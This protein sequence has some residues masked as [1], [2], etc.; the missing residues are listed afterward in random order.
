MAEDG[1]SSH[2]RIP[3]G[4]FYENENEF[5]R[6]VCRD[7]PDIR[8]N[9]RAVQDSAAKLAR[10]VEEQ[11][12]ESVQLR[13]EALDNMLT[14]DLKKEPSVK[15]GTGKEGVDYYIYTPKEKQKKGTLKRYT[16]RDFEAAVYEYRD[17][18]ASAV[19]TV[20][21]ILRKL[22]EKCDDDITSVRQSTHWALFF[23]AARLHTSA[24]QQRKWCIPEMI[25]FPNQFEDGDVGRVIPA[26]K[27]SLYGNREKADAQRIA[28]GMM[29]TGMIPYWMKR[30]SA[31]ANDIELAGMVLLTAPNMSGKSTLM[32]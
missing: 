21:T 11:I 8:A 17:A 30:S 1:I 27:L 4:F 15:D 20:K 26:S 12:P 29:L 9:Y 3:D 25:D 31:S 16:T 13:F 22:C 10:I 19:S 14:M 6:K 32:R 5:R 18:C 28:R 7:H 2:F 24:A 23:E